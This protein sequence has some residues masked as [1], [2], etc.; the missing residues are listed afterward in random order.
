MKIMKNG[1]IRIVSYC[2]SFEI[3]ENKKVE[4]VVA[5][6]KLLNT[7]IIGRQKLHTFRLEQI[8]GF[9]CMFSK[10]FLQIMSIIRLLPG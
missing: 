2:F 8:R 4:T 7:I 3:E 6:F 10:I 5:Y 9:K 1:D